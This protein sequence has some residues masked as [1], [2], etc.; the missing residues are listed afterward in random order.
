MPKIILHTVIN[1]PLELCFDLSTSIDLHLASTSHTNEKVVA[2]K[3]SGLVQKE[4][5]ITWEARHL[6]VRQR[7]TSKITEFRRPEFFED[8]MVKGA[9]SSLIHKHYFYNEGG[10]TVMKDEFSFSSPFGIAGR[11]FN[12]IFLT[13]YLKSFLLARNRIIKDCAE[14]EEW[15]KYLN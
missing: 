1:A 9:F 7:L 5:V 6:G 4:D 2:G 13:R 3:A 11:L 8:R 10:A 15:K 14:S 12:S